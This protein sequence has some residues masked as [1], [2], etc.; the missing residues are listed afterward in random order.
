MAAGIRHL[1]CHLTRGLSSGGP[2]ALHPPYVSPSA[3]PSAGRKS[4]SGG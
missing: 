2:G 1:D 3:S 4:S